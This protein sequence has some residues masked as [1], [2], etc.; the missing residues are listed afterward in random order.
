MENSFGN[1][2]PAKQRRGPGEGG[3][4]ED[5]ER[6][7]DE[8]GETDWRLEMAEVV[9]KTVKLSKSSLATHVKA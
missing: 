8:K 3:R 9:E 7:L 2:G 6:A 5:S 1:V 4:A